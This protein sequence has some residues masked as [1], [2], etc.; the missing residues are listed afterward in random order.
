M[1][2][3]ARPRRSQATPVVPD[4]ESFLIWAVNGRRDIVQRIRK[5]MESHDAEAGR[6]LRG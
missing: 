3:T 5:A 4:A 6:P 1:A 2:L